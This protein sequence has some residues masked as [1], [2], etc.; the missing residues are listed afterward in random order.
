MDAL[1]GKF[2]PV[3]RAKVGS[4]G[5]EIGIER[6]RGEISVPFCQP[7]AKIGKMPLV[8]ISI[9]HRSDSN[10]LEIVD[11]VGV[12]GRFNGLAQRGKEK[13]REDGDDGDHDQQFNQGEGAGPSPGKRA[14]VTHRGHN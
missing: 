8:V 7:I 14:R 4:L 13:T 5:V 9:K 2:L 3:G 6:S 11:A 10:L 12:S 1:L